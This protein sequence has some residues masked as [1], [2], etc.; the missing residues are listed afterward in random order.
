M[1]APPSLIPQPARLELRKGFLELD[2][3]SAIV[4]AKR[5]LAATRVGRQ[6]AQWLRQSRQLQLAVRED[7]RA[8]TRIELVL[9]AKAPIAGPE[10]YRLEVDARRARITA[11]EEAG[12][13]YGAVTLNQ[14]ADAIPS[15]GRIRLPALRIVDAPRFAWRGLMLDVARHY[16]PVPEIE[17]LLDAM[18][19][20]KL[21]VFHWHLTDDQGWRLQ[22]RRYPQLTG[23]GAW[24][25]SPLPGQDGQP[26]RYGGWYSQD[27]VRRI[28]AYAA[29]RHITVLPEIDMPGH[30]QAA[31]AAMP[32]I[33]VPG[34]ARPA[35]SPDWGVNPYLYGPQEETF[36]VMQ[37]VLAEV[38]ELFPSTYIHVGGDEAIKDQWQASPQVQ[39]RMRELGI[40]DEHALQSWFIGRLGRYLAA[41]GRRLIGWDEI[42]EGGLPA[43][44]TV[45]SW[46]GTQ[47]AIDAARLGH[48]VVLAPAPVLYLN[49]LES[50][51]DDEPAGRL[52][53]QTVA[54]VYAF[55]PVPAELDAAQARHVLGAQANLWTEYVTAPDATFRAFFP[56]AS[57]L[58]ERAWSPA[59][60]RDPADFLRRLPA[61]L[62]RLRS[63]G[64]P[65][66]DTVFA[67]D[68]TSPTP[69]A[70]ALDS[71][72]VDVLL[73]SQAGLGTLR[74]TLDG[75]APRPS[76]PVYGAPLKLALPVL[77]RAATFGD[78]GQLLAAP[79]ERRFDRGSLLARGSEQLEPCRDQGINLRVPLRPDDA[80]GGP[81]YDVE[82]FDAC[83][84]YR[85]APLAGIAGATVEAAT[86]P[87]NFQL[88]HESAG[89]VLRPSSLAA[90]DLEVR[91]DDCS[92]PRLALAPL[93]ANAA[94]AGT[95]YAL[96]LRWPAT[97][98]VHD[99][100]VRFN[101]V[102]AS[103]L[104]AIGAIRL[105]PAP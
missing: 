56:R 86:L 95:R 70:Q 21:N 20:H 93:P 30:A 77:V 5:D 90:G 44:S 64:V 31:V 59:T 39:A 47:G 22:I 80:S 6:L 78:N 29:A 76:S 27:E 83:W 81:L 40:A 68:I 100:C 57:A 92:G 3:A 28:V 52:L 42:L 65:A 49:H 14:L 96:D 35:V 45:M 61:Q 69:A 8:S 46:R 58:A 19:L 24:R 98:G 79:R 53:P 89:R 11:R 60:Q 82:L 37:N 32:E 103:L 91:L 63:L 48:D 13:F 43:S 38:L 41:H 26:Q 33:G 25:L 36:T 73:S 51:R 71:G 54:D 84:I 88:A 102:A 101:G 16:M 2:D 87:W 4:V 10:G 85:A 9:D 75:S 97:S 74:Y 62:A 50:R 67:A 7:G 34:V 12:L 66:S 99:L 15:S 94:L 72:S 1:S 104:P 17:R 18:A 23:I 55:E 105:E